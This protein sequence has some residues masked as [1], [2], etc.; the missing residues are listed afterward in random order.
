MVDLPKTCTSGLAKIGDYMPC[1]DVVQHSRIDLDVQAIVS[2]IGVNDAGETRNLPA[3][4][5]MYTVRN[6]PRTDHHG[7]TPTCCWDPPG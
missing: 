3:A 1:T 4:K 6:R 5:S 7:S 2:D